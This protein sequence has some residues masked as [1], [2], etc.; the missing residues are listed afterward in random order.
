[1]AGLI[2]TTAAINFKAFEETVAELKAELATL[3]MP[4]EGYARVC[5]HS[6][7]PTTP[8]MTIKNAVRA[9]LSAALLENGDVEA[10]MFEVLLDG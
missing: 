2:E 1:V 7:V 5:W 8:A 10:M 3:L 4:P 6:D 9:A